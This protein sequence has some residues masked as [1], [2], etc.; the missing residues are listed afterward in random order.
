MKKIFIS[1]TLIK[2]KPTLILT[3]SVNFATLEEFASFD[4]LMELERSK[5][6]NLAEKISL[7]EAFTPE[8]MLLPL[9]E[10]QMVYGT[11]ATYSWS[12]DKLVSI[13][14]RD[15]YKMVYYS[16]RPMLFVKGTKDTFSDNN[17]FLCLRRDC[18]LNIPEGEIVGV[19][20]KHGEIIGFSL[21]NDQT[22]LS[23]EKDNPLYQSQAK[24]FLGS[25]SML[26]MILL[27]QA[28]P[29]TIITT[30]VVRCSEVIAELSYS[31]ENFSKNIQ[32]IVKHLMDLKIFPFGG[33]VFLG[34]GV[35]YPKN[36][37]L[38]ENDQ[39]VINSDL[40]PIPLKNNYKIL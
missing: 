33:F 15:P 6:Y 34:C 2:N 1:K 35:S 23:F 13:D 32:E 20:N 30:Q 39:A 21:G 38:R 22:A 7:T 17:G 8:H 18:E 25:G 16:K 4:A 31:T 27:S 5:L 37:P 28:L 11:G 36:L 29:N 3:D 14:S 40:F 19:F 12:A 24:F 9:L 10:S 26:P